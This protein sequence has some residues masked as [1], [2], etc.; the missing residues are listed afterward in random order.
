[1]TTVILSVLLSLPFPAPPLTPTLGIGR[2]MPV[3]QSKPAEAATGGLGTKLP[4]TGFATYYGKGIFPKVV[5]NRIRWGHITEDQCPECIG[6]AAMLWPN[7]IGRVVCIEI[8]DAVTGT[9]LFGPLLVVDSAAAHHR[10][11]LIDGDWVIDLDY[12]LW[13]ALRFWNAPTQVIVKDCQWIKRM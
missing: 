7:D 13:K 8:D 5:A 1:M 10:K 2:I 3:A 11:T 6:Y 4:V 12:P 9:W